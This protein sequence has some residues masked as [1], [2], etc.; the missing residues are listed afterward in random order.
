MHS[1]HKSERTA[2]HRS[3]IRGKINVE[4]IFFA[5]TQPH[6]TTHP[7]VGMSGFAV[8]C[9]CAFPMC[10]EPVVNLRKHEN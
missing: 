9:V 4:C 2:E 3:V 7:P 5:L 10:T 6:P 8:L 1:S